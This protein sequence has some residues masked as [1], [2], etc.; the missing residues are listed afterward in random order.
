MTDRAKR[1][2]KWP[3][4][5]SLLATNLW[6]TPIASSYRRSELTEWYV[7]EAAGLE[8]GFTLVGCPGGARP[9]EPLVIR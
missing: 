2:R 1:S 8:Q 3:T 7:S 4:G 6:A 9:G 5:S